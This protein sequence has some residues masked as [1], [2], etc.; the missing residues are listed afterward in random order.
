MES[1]N[2]PDE[3]LVLLFR[4]GNNDAFDIL[5]LR[6]ADKM[7]A[8][9]RKIVM[10][11]EEVNDVFQD[12]SIHLSF[13]L[14]NNYQESGKFINWLH[15]VVDNYLYSYC[16]KKRIKIT[17]LDLE[18]VKVTQTDT[19]YVLTPQDRELKFIELRKSVKELPDDLQRLVEMKIWQQMTL[20]A[21]AFKLNMKKSTVAKRLQSAYN[22]IEESMIAKGYDDAFI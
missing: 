22:K 21:I 5:L 19:D 3:Q 12:L 14:K 7:K 2:D 6:Y 18:Q 16:R 20:N 10:N 13:K 8:S 11:N 17:D 4:L 1:H 9:I 15:R